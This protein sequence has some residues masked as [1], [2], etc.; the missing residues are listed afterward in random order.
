LAD[1]RSLANHK[2]HQAIGEMARND[3]LMPSL[4]RVL[5]DHARIGKIFYRY[6]AQAQCLQSWQAAIDHHEQIISAIES[7]DAS[8][9]EQIIHDHMNLS[10]KCLIDYVT[11]T[12]LSIPSTIIN[13]E[14]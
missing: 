7:R 13:K 4:R 11:P 10:H 6:P 3:Y 9:I 2:F 12:K 8:N 14:E 1:E 5:I